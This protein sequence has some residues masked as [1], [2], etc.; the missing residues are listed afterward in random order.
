[1]SNSNQS[2]VLSI[3]EQIKKLQEKKKREIEKL[4]KNAGKKF[5]EVFDLKEKSIEEINQFILILKQK[6]DITNIDE[7]SNYEVADKQD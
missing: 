2:K 3:D 5:L 7:P 6:S 1:M 4:E